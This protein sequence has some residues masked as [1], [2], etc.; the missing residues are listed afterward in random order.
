MPPLA[1]GNRGVAGGAAVQEIPRISAMNRLRSTRPR[2]VTKGSRAAGPGSEEC[3][4]EEQLGPGGIGQFFLHGYA[5]R[6]PRT[7]HDP[8]IYA[9]ERPHNCGAELR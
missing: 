8:L 9:G 7:A 5:N 3:G 4:S 6:L 2:L 1:G